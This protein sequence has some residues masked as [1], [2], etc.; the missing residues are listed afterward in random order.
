MSQNYLIRID[1]P[2][3]QLTRPALVPRQK[4]Q[5]LKR[6][7]ETVFFLHAF[8]GILQADMFNR[9]RLLFSA[10]HQGGVFIEVPCRLHT[11][12]KI[13]D[14]HIS[15]K[16][17]TTEEALKRISELYAIGYGRCRSPASERL[18][19]KQMQSKP[20]LT[21]LYKLRYK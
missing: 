10:E 19:H 14:V 20:L 18:T 3:R 8:R 9:Y 13:H 4:E 1:E 17:T 16:N 2:E 21:P 7:E 12:H 11:R 15:T 6:V 5:Q